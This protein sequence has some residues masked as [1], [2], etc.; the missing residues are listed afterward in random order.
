VK[1]A[2]LSPAAESLSLKYALNYAGISPADID[3]AVVCAQNAL[4]DPANQ[5]ERNEMLDVKRN[6]IPVYRLSHHAGHAISAYATSGF[7]EADV[8]VIDGMGSPCEDFSED[9]TAAIVEAVPNGWETASL[10]HAGPS[11]LRALEKHVVANGQWLGKPPPG[12]SMPSFGGLGGMYSAV[13]W[14]VF[15]HAM[16]AGKVMGLAPYGKPVYPSSEFFEIHGREF[17]YPARIQRHYTKLEHWPQNQQ[18]FCNL[19]SSVQVALEEALMYFVGHLRALQPS[20]NLAYAGG[21]ALNSVGNERIIRESGFDN[22]YIVPPAEDSGTAIGAAYFGLWKY[23]GRPVGVTLSRDAFGCEYSRAQVNEAVAR[24]PAITVSATD[25]TIEAASELLADGKIVGWFDGRSELGPRALGQRSILCDPRR[26]DAKDVLNRRVKQRE[27]F[28]PFA[29]VILEEEVGEWF[30]VGGVDATSP[31]MLRVYPFREDKKDL[32]PGVVH[33]DGTGRVQTVSRETNGRYYAVVQSFFRR[34]GVPILLNT[35]LNVMGEPIV[36]TPE[37]ALWSLLM[38]GMDACVFP[39]QVVTKSDASRSIMDMFPYRIVPESA[40]R[41]KMVND[42][43]HLEFDVATPWGQCSFSMMQPMPVELA[44]YL[45][46]RLIDGATSVG[47]ILE[48]AA[49]TDPAVTEHMLILT[50][51]QLRRTRVISFSDVP[52]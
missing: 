43:K 12:S 16:E 24:V 34:T 30:E 13:A 41:K 25:D 27:A 42:A 37:D 23:L 6:G 1:R 14:Q 45:L 38:T 4:S 3:V 21:V 28:R 33:I 9:E 48:Q 20:G 18:D 2:R 29:P 39:T 7:A 36:E 5:I 19:S 32:V 26:P 46:D 15:G 31:F 44:A 51:A 11:G 35:S 17:S 50:L 52:R 47:R 40:I 10:Y 8:L 22:V 49:A